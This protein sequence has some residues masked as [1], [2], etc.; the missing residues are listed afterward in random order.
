MLGEE[1]LKGLAEQDRIIER[2]MAEEMGE[3]PAPAAEQEAEEPEA[4]EAADAGEEEAEAQAAKAEDEAEGEQGE[5]SAEAEPELLFG[6]WTDE[7]VIGLLD[8]LEKLDMDAVR[9]DLER[10][11]GGHL[12]GVAG[13]VKQLEAQLAAQKEWELD[14]KVFDGIK[15]L[16]Q[17]LGERMEEA[18]KSGLKIR[19]MDPMEAFRPIL[20]ETLN[21]RDQ[22]LAAAVNDRV[23]QR[24]LDRFVPDSQAIVGTPEWAKFVEGLSEEQVKPLLEWDAQD[25]NGNALVGMKN[26]EP[27]IA[28]FSQFKAQ[29]AEAK[30]KAE[31]E[32]KAKAEKAKASG[33]RLDGNKRSGTAGRGA[34]SV[35]RVNGASDDDEEQRA[36]EAVLYGR[37]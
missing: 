12:G 24:L 23:E 14:A 7:Q 4:D 26:A 32:A 30:A 17:A 33:R 1:E 18:F 34:A 22:Y 37:A 27:V 35:A 6:R 21:G 28:V 10:K 31:A 19:T 25:A 8:R 15:E 36:L 16:D 13:R 20:D 2:M 11:L 9:V 29:Q 5:A 3:R